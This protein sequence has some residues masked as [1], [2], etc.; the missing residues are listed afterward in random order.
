MDKTM[1]ELISKLFTPE[2]ALLV[3]IIIGIFTAI[4]TAVI[5]FFFGRR[6]KRFE[7]ELKSLKDE[8]L[9]KLRNDNARELKTLETILSAQN[10]VLVQNLQAEHDRS[11]KELEAE[12]TKKN[13][14]DLQK[15]QAELGEE[16]AESQA[17][18][19]YQ[20]EARKRLYEECEPLIFQFV[21][22][23]ENA[24]HRIYS[25]ART[26]R[27]GNL[28]DWLC[29]NDYYIASTMYHLLAPVVVYKLIQR[30]LTIVDLTLDKNID[31][32]YQLA[33][34][35][36]WSFTADFDFAWGLKVCPIPYDPNNKEWKAFRQDEPQ[37][38]WRQGLPIGR[39]DNAVE[40][41]IIRDPEPDGHQ[42]VM[43]F[44]EFESRLHQPDSILCETFSI[45]RD[46]MNCFHPENRP[47]L[48]R[49]LITQAHIYTA[50]V[51][52]HKQGSANT[53]LTVVPIPEIDRKLFYWRRDPDDVERQQLDE[54]FSVAE[55]YLKRSLDDLYQ[56]R[57]K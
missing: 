40:S 52:F 26:S 22:L 6:L 32:H 18:R 47:V 24:L 17:R 48:W 46:M 41:L 10:Q 36:A 3:L 56:G 11:L 29:D 55:A 15:L 7:I 31:T 25:L 33:K 9:E 49:M 5:K 2:I 38:Y 20:Y 1:I 50:I 28:P 43:S 13:Q 12:L 54:P 53:E 42:R 34:N 4:Y 35:L 19:D 30:R 44:G 14:A 45:V 39:F 16:H 51:K 37:T 23:S 21:E 8:D 27:H 57:E